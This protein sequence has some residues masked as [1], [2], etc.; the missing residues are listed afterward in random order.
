[1]VSPAG[2]GLIGSV[3]SSL[4]GG[5]FGKKKQKNDT[6]FQREFAQKGLGWK[7]QDGKK[8]GLHPLASIGG[9]G[10]QY[11]PTAGSPMADAAAGVGRG[12]ETYAARRQDAPL[13]KKQA[14]LIDAQIAES[15][16][17]TLL[18]AS[19]ARRPIYGPTPGVT[20]VTSGLEG[21]DPGEGGTRPVR[22][23][24]TPDMPARQKVSLGKD[25][26]VG[27]NPEAFEV[28]ISELLAGAA[29]YGPQWLAKK[30]SRN[31]SSRAQKN[32]PPTRKGTRLGELV[33]RGNFEYQWT[34]NGWKGRRK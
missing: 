1:M 31:M 26:A 32:A 2:L 3:G 10:A 20:G 17:R 12:I 16:S 15:R 18:N 28:G 33:T 25:S 19:N 13:A 9:V 30:I 34:K 6:A 29:I 4:L 14:E 24:P 23:E 22:R 27:P 7:I 21:M 5:I 11:Q 8:H